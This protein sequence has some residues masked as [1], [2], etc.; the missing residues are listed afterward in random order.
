MSK[1]WDSRFAPS[2]APYEMLEMGV[3]EGKYIN[4]IQGIPSSWK[5]YPKV[6][7]IKDK[8]DPTLN[9]YGVKS[10]QPLSEWQKNGWIMTDKNG[11]FAWYIHYFLGRRLGREGQ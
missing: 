2:Y 7:G 4:N 8:P 6:L 3:F 5:K 11:W 1:K 9:Y 10:R